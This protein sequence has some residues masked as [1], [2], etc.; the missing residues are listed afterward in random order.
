MD[1]RMPVWG[2]VW[3]V[4]LLV[5]MLAITGAVPAMGQE[6]QTGP[7]AG[8]AYTAGGAGQARGPAPPAGRTDL[9]I[10]IALSIG[11]SCL[12][13]GY[14]VGHVGAAALGAASE[15]PEMLGRGLIFVALA[16]GIAIY[17]L[18]ISILLW[19]KMG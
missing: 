12:G 4:V 19:I 2:T 11:L 14:A 6:A 16:E 3:T 5:G 13:A 8:G 15:R 9:A 17:G 18:L 1:R 7:G 10:A